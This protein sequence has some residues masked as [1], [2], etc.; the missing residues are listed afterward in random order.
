[1]KENINHNVEHTASEI[2]KPHIPEISWE[3]THI[4]GLSNTN[5]TSILF[6]FFVIFISF[7]ANKALKSKKKSK[8]RTFFLSFIQYMDNEIRNSFWP[9]DKN[10]KIA[11]KYFSLIVWIFLIVF[12]WNL[13][14]LIIDWLG[15]SVS[16]GI[17]HYFRPINSDL[18]TTLALAVIVVISFLGL[19]FKTH[20]TVWYTKSYLFNWKWDNIMEKSINV[21]VGWLHLIW[22]GSTAASLSLR[23][24]GNIFAW[25]ILIW[26]IS[27]LG[28]LMSS[29]LFEIGRFLSIPFWFFEL[30]VA[31]IQALVFA[32]L[33]IS[34]LANAKEKH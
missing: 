20:W 4:L 1:M 6:L 2:S 19:W 14:W 30:F 23:L 12:V 18:N 5:L 29:S 25:V 27:Y 21:F 8:I 15:M 11:R 24:F 32:G 9:G 34:Y 26:V 10:K 7:I 31:L 13:F 3:Q 16:W 17:L 22:I 28:V 33:T